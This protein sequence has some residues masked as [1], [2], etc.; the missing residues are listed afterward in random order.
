MVIDT[1]LSVRSY[2]LIRE[3]EMKIEAIDHLHIFVPNL[4]KAKELF[5]A[6]MGGGFTDTYGGDAYN[7]WNVY[8]FS[9]AELTE[10]I[11]AAEPLW[12]GLTC[13]RM[14]IF[15]ISFLIKDIDA[16]VAE[17]K[18]LGI[19]LLD[20]IGS[21]EAGF[22]KILVQAQFDPRDSFETMVEITELLD[23]AYA[24]DSP[25]LRII[26]HVELYVRDLK[27][28][29][30][31]FTALT[32]FEFSTPVTV[33]EIK[34]RTAMNALGLWITQPV[35]AD[36]PVAQTIATLGEGVHAIAFRTPN[37]EEGIA[38]AQLAGLSLV[39]QTDKKGLPKQAQFDPKDC[40]GM[41][42][43]FTERPDR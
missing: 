11:R 36:S 5:G 13:K 20:R 35:S 25:F 33:D 21:E 14:G 39:D 23:P 31:L 22:G 42:V 28:A 6:L 40:F 38:K 9:G 30:E 15:G 19:R 43:K 2:D 17:V 18:G 4:E 24:H 12:A 37:L 29:V 41:I 8:N 26:D 34:A 1:T 3:Y 27:R 32:G 16:R 7:C 10:P